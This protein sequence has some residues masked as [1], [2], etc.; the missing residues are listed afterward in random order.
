MGRPL[1]KFG[2]GLG[3]RYRQNAVILADFAA[4]SD[5][6]EE[7]L[8]RGQSLEELYKSLATQPGIRPPLFVAAMR[9]WK[10]SLEG[11]LH[12][13]RRTADAH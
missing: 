1:R 13:F 4:A 11:H 2:L 10:S 8:G 5:R 3:D 9:E 6:F 7:A 12:L